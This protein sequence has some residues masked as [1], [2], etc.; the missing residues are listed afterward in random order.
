MWILQ[1]ACSFLD[2]QDGKEV[3]FLRVLT[4]SLLMSKLVSN[5]YPD[6]AG[7][8]ADDLGMGSVMI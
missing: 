6:N 8:G 1:T 5:H 2:H 4:I 3:H 7:L